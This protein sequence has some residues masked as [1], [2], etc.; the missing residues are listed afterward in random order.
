MDA[1]RRH[2]LRRSRVDE[3]DADHEG[4]EREDRPAV[5]RHAAADARLMRCHGRRGRSARGAMVLPLD[6][7][8][9][10]TR[11]RHRRSGRLTARRA[12]ARRGLRGLRC[13]AA[14]RVV[15]VSRTSTAIRERDRALAGGRSRRALARR[16]AERESA[17]GGLQPR[18]P[19]FVPMSWR[20]PVLTAEFAAVGCTALLEA[21]R[22][23]G[24]RDSLLP[25]VVERD[26][27]RAARGATERGNAARARDAVR[28]RQ[29]VR[30][31]HHAELPPPVRA[32]RLVGDPLQ[33]RVA[34]ASARLRDAE[35][36]ARR[37]RDQPRS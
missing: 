24:R 3:R 6:G 5:G 13:R 15:A 14:A 22:R 1:R 4:R 18:R 7:R 2:E 32:S 9:S 35:G 29:G 31:L 16:R 19:S 27:R 30:A 37:G 23:V 11:H 8:P 12:A 25:G 10:R 34:A 21:I 28:R 26:L 20:Q 33:P 36:D 17:A